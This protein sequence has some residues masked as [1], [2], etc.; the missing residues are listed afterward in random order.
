MTHEELREAV[1]GIAFEIARLDP[2][3]AAALRRGPLAGAG[4][5]AFWRLLAKYDPKGVEK[6]KAGWAVLI[7]AIAILTSKG[8]NP[9]K[10]SSHDHNASMGGTL[11][12]AGVSELRLARLLAAPAEKRRQLALRLC[13]R[14]SAADHNRFNLVPLARFILFGDD[15]TDRWIAREYYRAE[16]ES[17]KNEKKEMPS[18]A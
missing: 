7:Q 17:E 8:R 2:G 13:R 4:A 9:D 18:D 12:G 5:A 6:N 14:L 16:R 3:P 15:R 1:P 11:F 10:R